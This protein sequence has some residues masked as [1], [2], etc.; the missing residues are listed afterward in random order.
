M[1][2]APSAS[3]TVYAPKRVGMVIPDLEHDAHDGTLAAADAWFKSLM[4]KVVAGKDWT[5]GHLAV[6]LT[7]DEDDRAS[8][9]RVL[10]VVIHRSQQGHVVTDPLTH[11]SLTRLYDEVAQLPLLHQARTA[12]S[13]A[14]AFGLP[15]R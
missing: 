5:S 12:P 15:V 8:G 1:P 11:Y 9:N 3:W 14:T 2:P 10:T 7:A 13:M 4:T 6:V